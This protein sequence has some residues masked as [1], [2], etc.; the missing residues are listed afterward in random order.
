MTEIEANYGVDHVREWTEMKPPKKWGRTKEGFPLHS[1]ALL[2]QTDPR[3][4]PYVG[5]VNNIII[6]INQEGVRSRKVRVIFVDKINANPT[7][8]QRMFDLIGP[9]IY[10]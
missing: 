10:H 1:Q 4:F 6:P 5:L 8:F 2:S 9:L 7:I 3:V